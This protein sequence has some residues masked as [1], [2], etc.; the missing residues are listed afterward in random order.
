[1]NEIELRDDQLRRILAGDDLVPSSG[2]TRSVMDAVLREST[3]PQPIPFPWK[4]AV[5]GI[6]VA[7]AVLVVLIVTIVQSVLATPAFTA[8]EA[9]SVRALAASGEDTLRHL[10]NSSTAG[11]WTVIA[12]LTCAASLF[13]PFRMATQKS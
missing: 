10:M 4:W 1:M 11:V 7:V 5:P 9:F 8:V 12:L 6:L 2:F 3:A 13:I